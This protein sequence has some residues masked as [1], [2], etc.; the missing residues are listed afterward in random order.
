MLAIVSTLRYISCMFKLPDYSSF[1]FPTIKFPDLKLPDF[2]LPD[3][4]LADLKFPAIDFPTIDLPGLDFSSLDVNALRDR[5]GSID[6]TKVTESAAK[7]TG[8]VRDAAYIAI[9]LGV[10]SVEMVKARREQLTAIV[11]DGLDQARGLL[12]N[13]V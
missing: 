5:L 7:L 2:K 12:R 6:T 1:D 4:K 3:F 9:G 8:A 10:T 13:S 11:T